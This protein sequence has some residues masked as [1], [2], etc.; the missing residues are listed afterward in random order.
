MKLLIVTQTVDTEHS[1]LG[2]F[3]RWIEEFAKHC[4]K[5]TVICLHTGKYSFS[6][7][8]EVI[9][10]GRASHFTRTMRLW[11]ICISRRREYDAVFVH[12]NPEYIVAAGFLWKI[13]HKRIALWYTH[14][15]VNLKLRIAVLFAHIIFSASAESFRLR[16]KK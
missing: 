11:R 4:E 15:S 6:N 2:F 8:V 12:M 1:V 9:A 7:N 5:V 14:K 3:V 10:L 13:M 16:T